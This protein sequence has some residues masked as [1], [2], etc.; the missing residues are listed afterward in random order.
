MI[1]ETQR[2]RPLALGQVAAELH[3]TAQRNACVQLFGLAPLGVADRLGQ[4]EDVLGVAGRHEQHAIVIAQDQVRRIHDPISHRG[5]RQ[6]IGDPGIKTLR[7][8]RDRSEAED[9]QPDR[10]DVCGVA[11]QAPDQHS[12][13]P[14][15]LSL[16]NHQ[17]AD[18]TLI[19]APAVVG[20]QHLA[21]C[22]PFERLEKDVDA[23]GM[24]GR[25]HSPSQPAT[26]P[27][28]V[29]TRGRAAHREVSA[30]ACIGQM[31]RGQRRKPAPELLVIHTVHLPA[32]VFAVMVDLTM[33]G[34]L[35]WRSQSQCGTIGLQMEPIELGGRLG[36]WSP[37]RGP[38]PVLL[39]A[40]LRRLIDEGELPPG[41]PLPPDRALASALAVG[42]STVV[43]A[44]DL[45]RR[46]GRIVRRQGSGTQVAGTA[47]A[48]ARPTT[49]APLFLHLLE[50]RDGV[51]EL[52]CAAPGTPPPELAAA[53]ASIVPALAG[54]RGDI[55][56]RPMGHPVLRAAIAERYTR[57][58]I[59]TSPDRI[60]VTT[61]A[62]QALSLLARAFLS[63]GARVLVEAPTYHGAL[64]VFR[65]AAAVPRALR[66]GSAGWRWPRG[67]TTP[68]WPT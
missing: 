25:T 16:Q 51:I 18:A 26:G 46:D 57:R 22:G 4:R 65:D 13:Q 24:A 39:A 61:G 32:L 31:S 14:R 44:Y 66:S 6:R 33:L 2:G 59:R 67:S 53:Y 30:E 37:G 36:R 29:H 60:L 5:G 21:R 55:G 9:R 3:L 23:A 45:L 11:M 49:G 54:I 41:E 38:L 10:L 7:A 58:G 1:A 8:G 35:G 43:A 28:R 15:R 48:A 19:E 52:T 27:H 50:P 56:Y 64:E 63:P 20:Y 34:A 12:G 68:P 62:Q 42:R 17:V 47:R 40:R